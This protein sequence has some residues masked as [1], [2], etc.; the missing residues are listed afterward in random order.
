MWGLREKVVKDIQGLW[1]FTK[2]GKTR[3]GEVL[4]IEVKN[5]GLAVCLKY[6]GDV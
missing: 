5:P 2:E 6:L 3:E 4:G 1:P